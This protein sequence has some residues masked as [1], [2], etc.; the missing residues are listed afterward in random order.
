[1]KGA[2]A[3]LAHEISVCPRIHFRNSGILGKPSF[4]TVMK[5][6]GRE[7]KA[8]DRPYG[9]QRSVGLIRVETPIGIL[10]EVF[11]TVEAVAKTAQSRSVL[12]R[13]LT[14]PLIEVT[15]QTEVGFRR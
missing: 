7:E 8:L 15:R 13:V 9:I 5:R 1:M 2:P 14:S 4:V 10:V 3:S 6:E 12:I 11:V